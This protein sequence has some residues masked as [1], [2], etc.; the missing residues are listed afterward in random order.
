[1][2][3]SFF[4]RPVAAITARRSSSLHFFH[5]TGKNTAALPWHH[6]HGWPA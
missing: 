6:A 3:G 5:L 2:R 4:G 1:V